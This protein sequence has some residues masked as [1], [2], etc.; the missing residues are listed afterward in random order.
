MLTRYL[1]NRKFAIPVIDFNGSAD[2]HHQVYID[3]VS[4]RLTTSQLLASVDQ[5][6]T[7]MTN[8]LYMNEGKW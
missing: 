7:R 5:K 1:I 4:Q 2:F 6:N 3:E 8:I